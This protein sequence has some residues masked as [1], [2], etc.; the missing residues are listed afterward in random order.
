MFGT[1][2]SFCHALT[3][4]FPFTTLYGLNSG[5]LKYQHYTFPRLETILTN[6]ATELLLSPTECVKAV[7]FFV[8]W[9]LSKENVAFKT[10]QHGIQKKTAFWF[11]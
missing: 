11:R 9:V 6:N 3:A 5:Q 10:S 8:G 4:S 1:D 7:L 2:K